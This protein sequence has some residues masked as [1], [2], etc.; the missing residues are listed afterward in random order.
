MGSWVSLAAV[1]I[2]LTALLGA[3]LRLVLAGSVPPFGDFG[4]LRH[5]HTHLGYYG[6]LFPLMWLAWAGR[7]GPQ[8]GPRWRWLYG[9]SVVVSVIGFVR[10]GYG[11][12][13]I[14]GSTAVL[15]GWLWSAAAL[16]RRRDRG[17]LG[18]AAWGVLLGSAMI[19]WVAA[20]VS[21]GR[22]GF[23][24]RSFLGLLLLGALTPSAMARIDAKP[25]PRWLW[26]LS[27]T[28]G[29]LALG[30][31]EGPHLAALAL[32]GLLLGRS[33]LSAELPHP[34]RFA[35][36]VTAAG[37]TLMGLHLLEL[38]HSAA[39]AGVHFV[40]LGPLLMTFWPRRIGEGWSWGYLALVGT[41]SGAILSQQWG[42]LAQGPKIAAWSGVAIAM[43]LVFE[44]TTALIQRK[45]GAAE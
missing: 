35:W 32:V 27:T 6:G 22:S 14:A 30:A 15:V 13:A 41:M 37:L 11:P 1:S 17:W 42:L 16:F 26:V 39:V 36:L 19:P 3:A 24:A 7:G 34:L 43:A 5:A 9:V 21:T 44:A 8:F 10:A 20:S 18:A 25:W 28:V 31:V 2:A 45:A 23:V 38:S 29:A 4:F 12:I 40:V 33:V